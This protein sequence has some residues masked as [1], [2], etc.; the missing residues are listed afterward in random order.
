MRLLGAIAQRRAEARF[1]CASRRGLEAGLFIRAD[2]ATHGTEGR[3]VQDKVCSTALAG[4]KPSELAVSLNPPASRV[5]CTMI[6][7]RPY[8]AVECQPGSFAGIPRR[9]LERAAIPADAVRRKTPAQRLETVA[10]IGR[11]FERQFNRPIVRQID[12]PPVS[13]GEPFARRPGTG[14]GI[15]QMHRIRPVVAE[16]DLPTRVERKVFARQ[17][18]GIRFE[19]KNRHEDWRR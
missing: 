17:I 8:H 12:G 13:I 18:R 7:A 15:L 4:S 5:D 19:N 14:A 3:G 10:D 16:M 6:C 11:L 1:G 9:Q 2:L